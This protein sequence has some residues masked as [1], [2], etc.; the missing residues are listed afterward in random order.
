VSG[1]FVDKYNKKNVFVISTIL[2]GAVSFGYAFAKNVP[3]LF[4]LRIL[5]GILFGVSTTCTTALV[6]PLSR[7]IA[8]A[9]AWDTSMRVSW[10]GRHFGPAIGVAIKDL[11]GFS[12]LYVIVG[13]CIC[14]HLFCACLPICQITGAA[15]A[16]HGKRKQKVQVFVQR[17]Y[18][19]AILSCMHWFVVFSPSIME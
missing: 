9:R 6:S 19:Q 16:S 11:I 5:H 17:L 18:C 13:V 4:A 8:L 14:L 7:K 3:S 12:W 15:G 2:F 10:W 1:W